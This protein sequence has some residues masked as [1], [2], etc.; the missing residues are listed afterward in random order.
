MSERVGKPLE[1]LPLAIKVS[2]KEIGRAHPKYAP[3][4]GTAFDGAGT[5]IDV[6]HLEQAA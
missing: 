1:A 5:G 6:N 4:P 2:F 3:A